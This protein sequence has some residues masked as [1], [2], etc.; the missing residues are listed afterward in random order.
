MEAIKLQS[1]TELENRLEALA[2]QFENKVGLKKL[3][4][5][6]DEN[7]YL[8][9]YITSY[10]KEIR[11]HI[12][13]WYYNDNLPPTF[14][15]FL[16]RFS[17]TSIKYVETATKMYEFLQKENYTKEELALAYEIVVLSESMRGREGKRSNIGLDNL[18]DK[19]LSEL[20]EIIDEVH[21]DTLGEKEEIINTIAQ[22][23]LSG[24]SSAQELQ[25]KFISYIENSNEELSLENIEEID[26]KTNGL[27]RR[28]LR[29]F[30]SYSIAK[31]N[32]Q[33]KSYR[34]VYDKLKAKS[35]SIIEKQNLKISL[36]K[37]IAERLQTK[38]KDT[39][40]L[41]SILQRIDTLNFLNDNLD[42]KFSFKSWTGLLHWSI[43]AKAI[44]ATGYEMTIS[45]R[46]NLLYNN[47]NQ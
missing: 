2:L 26:L 28:I 7:P 29:Y 15:G 43:M 1:V 39:N 14:Q 30:C 42:V 24:H 33:L 20:E 45:E 34:A 17:E 35:K 37:R 4:N 3:I 40:H 12:K 13:E 19:F 32:K 36:T 6:F 8:P 46:I 44:E 11:Q 21:D 47:Q 18:Q 16:F 10:Q 9:E 27:A 5:F 31:F 22:T 23:V 38:G 41:N 25:E